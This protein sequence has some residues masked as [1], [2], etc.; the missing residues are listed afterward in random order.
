[1]QNV[2]GSWFMTLLTTS[3]VLVAL[4]Q[5]ATSLPVFLVGLP[6]GALADIVDRRRLLLLTQG[7]MLLVAVALSAVT[8]LG[9]MTPSSLLGLTFALGLGSAMNMP[10]WQ[11]ITPEI[12]PREDLTAAV[13]LS[14]VSFNIARAIGP[15]LGG[16]LVATAG[17]AWVFLVNALSFVGVIIVIYRWRR[18]T[19]P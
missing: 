3:P 15:A 14:G 9:L 11:A 19:R 16:V 4:M 7:W 12:V 10:A 18:D 8:F 17:P 13:T 5:S 2:G 1:M 6:A